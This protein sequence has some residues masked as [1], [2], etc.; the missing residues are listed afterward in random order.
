MKKIAVVGFG[1]MG[2]VHAKNILESESLELCGIIDKRDGD[3]F[4]G[5]ESTGNGGKLDLLLERMRQVPVF[6]SIKACCKAVQP[7]AVS[8]CVPLFLHYKLAREALLLGLDVL[9]EKPFCQNTDQCT[10]L[11]ELSEKQ[12]RILM[13]AH[14]IRFAPEW[15][16]LAECIRDKRYGELQLLSTSRLGG[17]PT[18]GA[19][20][21]PEIKKT[22]GGA[23][24]DL[25]IHDLDFANYCLGTPEDVKV[26]LTT[27]EYYEIGLRYPGSE[28]QVSVKGGFLHCH[29]PFAAEFAATFERGSLRCSTMRPGIV[30]IGTDAGPDRIVTGGNLYRDELEYFAQCIDNRNKPI[31]CL[32][33]SSMLAIGICE[34][35]KQTI[36]G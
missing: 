35:I 17:E 33:E 20:T 32:P 7:D 22:C 15:N 27:G 29:A 26:N 1:F 19:W 10:K 14:C 23:L 5:I 24:F 16:F 12:K 6:K 2:V 21:N 31:K 13:V 28:A 8:I 36:Y 30:E 9:L 4:A 25:L 11:I 3:I 34:K 18:W